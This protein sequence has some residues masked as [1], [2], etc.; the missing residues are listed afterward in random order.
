MD[1]SGPLERITGLL[2][3]ITGLLDWSTGSGRHYKFQYPQCI[4]K[5]LLKDNLKCL[6][7]KQLKTEDKKK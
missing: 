7:N 6:V 1:W 5:S 4:I 3:W 2:E